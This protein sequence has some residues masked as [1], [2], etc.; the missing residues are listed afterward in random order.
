MNVLSLFDGMSCGRMALDRL[1]VKIDNYYASEIDKYAIIVSKYNF[2]DIIHIGD[3]RDINIEQLPKID[4]L[5][6]GS[7]CQGFSFAGKQMGSTTKTNIDITSLEQY[8]K[9]K[10]EGFEFDGQ[11]YLFWEY[12]YILEEIRKINPDVKFLLENVMMAKK[13]KDMFN[14]AVGCEPIMIN[15]NLVSAQT[16]K[17]LY[18]TNI[19]VDGIPEDKHIYLEDILELNENTT[20][21]Y[22]FNE[23]MIKKFEETARKETKKSING[24]HQLNN[25]VF[26]SNRIYSI[27]GKTPTLRASGPCKIRYKCGAS[28]GRYT[29]PNSNKTTQMMEIRKD[30]KTS[31]ITTVQ[32]DNYIIGLKDEISGQYPMDKFKKSDNI[33]DEFV[34]RKLTPLECERLQTLPDNY[35]KVPYKNKIMSDNQRYKM[36][37][38]GWTVDAICHLLK[39]IA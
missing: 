19:L 36:I 13:W 14:S 39:K 1:G 4:L 27:D 12:I 5:I 35:T 3:V 25:P 31:A 26:S 8:L 22:E 38:N 34:Y 15:S 6:G 16:R 10:D 23:D 2:P 7:P 33:T 37:G 24:I 9:L 32:K 28:R 21:K 29:D 20:S 18:W 11:S 30:Y 17:R